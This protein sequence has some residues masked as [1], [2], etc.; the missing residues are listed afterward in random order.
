MEKTEKIA[1][2]VFVGVVAIFLI[3]A[4]SL[5]LLTWPISE[6]SINKSGVFGDSFGALTSI[7]SGLA[8]AGVVWT[9]VSQRE[10][11]KVTR[12]ELKNQGFENAF[13]QMLKLHNQIINEIDLVN[14]R[15]EAGVVRTAGRDCFV[16]FVNR[17]FEHYDVQVRKG[18]DLEGEAN[19]LYAAYSSF[20]DDN[21]HELAH[22]FRFLYNIFKFIDES[23]IK[24]KQFYSRLVRA[25]LSDQELILIYYNSFGPYGKKF[26]SY[27]ETFQLMDNLQKSYVIH[28]SHMT[29]IS[30]KVKFCEP[31]A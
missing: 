16:T 24:N 19:R 7:F 4:A 31:E 22:Y 1:L 23:E 6:F 12:D 27:I 9:I 14:T 30:D 3:Y 15:K 26:Q 17:F 10:E 25:Q 2:G 11:L 13:F 20:W 28:E 8:F 5:I 18:D 21:G 29:L